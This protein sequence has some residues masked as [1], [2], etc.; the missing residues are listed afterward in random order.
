[1]STHARH[2]LLPLASAIFAAT[3]LVLTE[4]ALG[5]Y[6]VEPLLVIIGGN[7]AGGGVM[8]LMSADNLSGLRLVWR[9]RT[10]ATIVAGALFIYTVAY[11]MAFNA[12]ALIGAG[13][14][15]LL[16]QLETLFV[17]IFAIIFLGETLTRRRFMAVL[18]ALAGTVLINF[19]LQALEFSLGWG[20]LLAILAPLCIA[21]GI[22]TLKPVLDIADA[23]QVTGLALLLGAVFL[24]PFVP[25]MV[26]VFVISG[27][28]FVAI[29]LMGIFRGISWLTYN[30]GL[31]RIGASQSAIIFISFAFFTVMFQAGVARL[32][33]TLGVQLP[34]NLTAALMGG[35]LIAVGIVILQTDPAKT[36]SGPPPEEEQILI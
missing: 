16:G 34:S 10:L 33:P 36:D 2:S 13:K 1:M 23:R 22:I 29:G 6:A 8:L 14:A 18:L 20:G 35:T 9:W 28:A 15:A 4:I 12:I 26:S 32:A 24:T 17:V 25:V 7:L 27:A 11:L 21:A 19:D 5:F 31:Q 30:M 3:A